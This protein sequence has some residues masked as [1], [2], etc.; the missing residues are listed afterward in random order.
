MNMQNGGRAGL[1]DRRFFARNTLRL[2]EG[3]GAAAVYAIVSLLT[4]FLFARTHAFF[5]AYPFAIGYLAAVDRRVPFAFLGGLLGA[6]TLGERGGAYAAAYLLLF[7][8]RMLLSYPREGGRLLPPSRA[9]FEEEGGLRAAAAC[10]CA[11]FLSL[12]A[13]VTGSL[14]QDA[15][16]FS[17]TLLPLAVLSCIAYVFYF[18]AGC[19]LLSCLTGEGLPAG[20]AAWPLVLSLG[21]LSFTV[22]RGAGGVELLG[23]SLSY[24]AAV[25]FAL[26]F[27][28]RFGI[29]R[30]G[31]AAGLAALGACLSLSSVVYLPALVTV[32]V[33]AAL[34]WRFGAGYAV[35]GGAAG[36]GCLAYLLAGRVALLS[37]LP[38]LFLC[39]VL[40]LPLFRALP[41][42]C[43]SGAERERRQAGPP[44]VQHGGGERML[45]LATAFSSL[46][47]VFYR[48]S[49]RSLHIEGGCVRGDRNEMLGQTWQMMAALLQDAARREA[50]TGQEDATATA[51]AARVLEEM[52]AKARRV[53][54]SAARPRVLKASGVRWEA[55]HPEEGALR[56]RLEEVCACRLS[57]PLISLRGGVCDMHYAAARR[58]SVLSCKAGA[59]GGREV[60]GDAFSVFTGEDGR[61]FSLLSDG[62]GSGREAAVTA[63]ICTAF[64]FGVL[65]AGVGKRTAATAL[66]GL[67]AMREGECTATL[68]LCEIDL[69]TGEACFFKCGAAASYVKRGESLFHIPAGRL[70]LGVLSEVDVE[71]TYFRLQEGDCVIFVSDGVSQ[72]P[73][74]ALW[75]CELLSDGWEEDTE[76]M[77]ERILQAAAAHA[78]ESDDRTVAILTIAPAGEK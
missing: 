18:N 74:D 78:G 53:S 36:G 7:L 21:A 47:E 17:A 65:E 71:K 40:A 72:T 76:W 3:R 33:L 30:G 75:L 77:A 54:V 8:L 28:Y 13:A 25:F 42:L 34:L 49:D 58:F 73:E 69:F 60:S 32:A 1:F 64:L 35:A 63:G 20:R 31:V 24:L 70:P 37:F 19:T 9:L 15:L 38:E 2:A 67:L 62:M 43:G 26:L 46:S 14:A 61:F 50:Q 68:D 41:R 48:L 51:A 4:A 6:L 16:F 44:A 52:G 29:L 10:A 57:P 5:G 27:S 59:A 11:L 66:N 23:M 22:V 12:C 39:P 55:D 56:R 45:Q